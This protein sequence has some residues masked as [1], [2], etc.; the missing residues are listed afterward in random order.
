MKILEGPDQCL[1]QCPSKMGMLEDDPTMGGNKEV[2]L[3]LSVPLRTP[4]LS[5]PERLLGWGP[6]Q[7]PSSEDQELLLVSYPSPADGALK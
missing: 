1:F 2:T 7:L 4:Q 3:T 5:F 6:H